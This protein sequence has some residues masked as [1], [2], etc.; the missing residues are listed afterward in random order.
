M[1]GDKLTPKQIAFVEEYLI[2]MNATRAYKAAGYSVKSENAAGVEGFKLLRN[3]K[4]EAYLHK[5]MD[6]RSKATQITAEST[7]RGI[8]NIA[9][10]NITDVVTLV[11]DENGAIKM[12][13]ADFDKLPRNIKAAIQSIKQ[14]KD[15]SIEIKMHDKLKALELQAKHQG[16]FEREIE[17]VT[18]V[19]INPFEGMSKDD[20]IK[21]A[22]MQ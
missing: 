4:I 13:V 18:N 6:E 20:L 12:Q 15:G 7:L 8:N 10:A 11:R 14:N 22:K 1:K 9:E 16:L 3:P 5:R 2:D 21:L 19:K 17:V